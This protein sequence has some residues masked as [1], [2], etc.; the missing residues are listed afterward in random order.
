MEDNIS[1]KSQ[2]SE[3]E[4]EII[5]NIEP[6]NQNKSKSPTLNLSVDIKELKSIMSD[7]CK[8]ERKFYLNAMGKETF[9]DE[10]FMFLTTPT[11]NKSLCLVTK[12]VWLM[13]RFILLDHSDKCGKSINTGILGAIHEDYFLISRQ[14]HDNCVILEGLS[15]S[16][17]KIPSSKTQ[18][19]P[20]FYIKRHNFF[21]QWVW[22]FGCSFI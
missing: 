21:A 20:C 8:E 1:S 14:F 6:K 16:H 18:F 17:F 19:I 2:S 4:F 3:S 5:T 15:L 9:A 11:Q 10:C 13:S 22:S 12:C 7:A